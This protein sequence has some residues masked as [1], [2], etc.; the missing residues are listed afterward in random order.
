MAC[1]SDQVS[2]SQQNKSKNGKKKEEEEEELQVDVTTKIS[3]QGL[4]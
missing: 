4:P 3:L 2:W 1:Y